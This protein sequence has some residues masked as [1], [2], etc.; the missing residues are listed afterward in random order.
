MQKVIIISDNNMKIEKL[1][2][3]EECIAH[4]EDA[5]KKF[6]NECANTTKDIF[7]NILDFDDFYSEGMIE[8]MKSYEK[9]EPKNTFN[10]FL[11]ENLNNLRIDTMRMINAKKRNTE[12]RIVSFDNELEDG[13]FL[14]DVE[15]DFDNNYSLIEFDES[16]A[17][18]M[19]KLTDEEKSIFDFLINNEKTKKIL[20]KELGITRPTLDVR[21]T[22]VKDKIIGLLPEYIN[23]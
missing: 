14:S 2:T 12:Q 19:S 7:N 13:T 18:A 5:V 6:A 17:D 11:H 1:M 9:Y 20:A 10:T 15:G 4:H 16:I 8:L 21:I 3:L 22:K 23:Y